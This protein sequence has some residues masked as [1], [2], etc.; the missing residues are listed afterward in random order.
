MPVALTRRQALAVELRRCW[1]GRMG[2][3]GRRWTGRRRERK[4]CT[5]Q[6]I[7][8]QSSPSSI[9]HRTNLSGGDDPSR[10]P[11]QL[12][13]SPTAR[14]WRRVMW[15]RRRCSGRSCARWQR[16][17]SAARL[18]DVLLVGSWS[19]CAVARITRRSRNGDDGGKPA[20]V[21]AADANASRV[22]SR[23][24]RPRSSRQHR[25]VSSHHCPSGSWATLAECGLPHCSH[26]PPARRKRTDWES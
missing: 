22:G 1:S 9:C 5:V 26:L 11:D 19:R 12:K 21:G 18:R 15:R 14:R 24:F 16:P 7:P 3:Q 8:G 4:S 13:R 17:H 2:P 10:L 20:N 23:A 25:W 6:D